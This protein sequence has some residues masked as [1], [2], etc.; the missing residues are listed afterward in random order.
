MSCAGC[1]GAFVICGGVWLVLGAIM[2]G[3]LD[4]GFRFRVGLHVAGRVRCLVFGSF[5]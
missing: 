1:G 4:P 5:S 2:G 3:M